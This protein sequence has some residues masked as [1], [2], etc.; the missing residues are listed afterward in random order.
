[1]LISEIIIEKETE[2]SVT[3]SKKSWEKI[4]KEILKTQKNFSKNSFN[5]FIG[6]VSL[7]HDPLDY[8]KSIRNEW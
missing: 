4:E 5:D 1:M 8:Q 2:D 6:K 3:I 7:N